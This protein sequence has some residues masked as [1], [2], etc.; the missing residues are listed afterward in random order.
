MIAAPILLASFL[1]FLYQSWLFARDGKIQ[2]R[3][4]MTG[5][6]IAR[7]MLN[8]NGFS[9]VPV[10]MMK[11]S[12]HDSTPSLRQ[13]YLSRD[14]YEGKT[15]GDIAG[16]AREAARL[17]LV[18][19]SVLPLRI[20]S[21]ISFLSQ[22]VIWAAWGS[23][24]LG[25]VGICPKFFD[26]TGIFLFILVFSLGLLRLPREWEVSEKAFHYLHQSRH[27]DLDEFIRL[28]NILG[29]LRLSLISQI[30]RV[31][32]EGIKNSFFSRKPR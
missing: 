20:Q 4:G 14:I 25:F 15:L 12:N 27:F 30:F 24:L 6:E 2:N 26:W 3:R 5:Y 28:R 23:Y 18:P 32:F 13:L 1:F 17:A 7:Q 16:A 11:K 29:A 10:E 22:A 31:P 21:R 8:G 9:E 19:S